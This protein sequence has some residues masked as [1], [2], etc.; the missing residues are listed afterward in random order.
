MSRLQS[1][2]DRAISAAST[3]DTSNSGCNAT[4]N[5]NTKTCTAKKEHNTTLSS[6]F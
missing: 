1:Q 4:S 5:R 2:P 6:F 3:C